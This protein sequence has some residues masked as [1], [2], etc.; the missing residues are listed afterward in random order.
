[1]NQVQPFAEIVV[2]IG[3]VPR[4]ARSGIVA[5]P[6]RRPETRESDDEE[7]EEQSTAAMP[8]IDS[9]EF[10]SFMKAL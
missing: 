7:E 1:L 5:R 2:V 3:I 10:L 6:A 9:H 4:S 8:E